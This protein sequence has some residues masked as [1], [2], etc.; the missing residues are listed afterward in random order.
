MYLTILTI[1]HVIISLA[2]IASGFFVL[3]GLL[4]GKR[5]ESWSSFFLVTTVATSATGFLF[6]VQ[7]FMPS[8]AVG[9]I[10]LIVLAVAIYARSSRQLKGAWGKIYVVG[11]VLA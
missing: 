3:R 5:S 7:H 2:G 6:P 8:H 9:I 4:N 1:G 11:A 10:S